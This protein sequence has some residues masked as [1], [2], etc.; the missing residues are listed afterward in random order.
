MDTV[1]VCDAMHPAGPDHLRSLGFDVR[2]QTGLSE[3]ELCAAVGGSAAMLIRSAT[4]V[5][6][7]VMEAAPALR[8][9]GRAGVG[10]DNVDVA[11][12]SRRGVMVMNT[13][14][15]NSVTTG[16]LAVAHILALARRIPEADRSMRA[17][18][19]DKKALVG[20]EVTGKTLGVI[21]LGKI[22]RVVAERGLGLSMKVVAYDPFLQGECPVAGASLVSLDQLLAGADFVSIHVPRTEETLGLVDAAAM[23]RMKP[24][25]CLV[26]CARGGIIDEQDLVAALDRGEIAGAALDVFVEEPLPDAHPLRQRDD[27]HLTPHLGA[28]SEEAQER[29]SLQIAEQVAD[30]LRDET[31]SCAVNAPF[32]SVGDNPDLASFITLARRSTLLLA[33]ASGSTIE[34]VKLTYRGACAT[35]EGEGLRA[36]ALAGALAP[37]LDGPV[38]LV[39]APLLASERGLR[40][41]EERDP[42]ARDYTNLLVVHARTS[43]GNDLMVAGTVFL[44]RPRLVMLDGCGIDAVP[45]GEML[46]IRNTNEPGVVGAVGTCLGAHGINIEGLHLGVPSDAADSAVALYSIGRALGPNELDEI[47]ALDP[48]LEAHTISL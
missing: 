46:L 16:E 29:V 1:F 24:T 22:G 2:E 19:W 39:N 9:V 15:A 7:N 38:N 44:G 45:E 8:I 12:A 26:N 30:Y 23:E 28:S 42:G 31:V 47:R 33:Q 5:T 40:I 20:S 25:A 35:W 43:D 11:E 32:L 36:A 18:R 41:T 3:E 27:V 10:V 48:V 21:G 34:S 17:G 37:V 6:A 4:R 14:E 13:P